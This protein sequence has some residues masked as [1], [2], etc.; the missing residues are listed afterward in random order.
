MYC[1][2]F[3]PSL[4]TTELILPPLF[5]ITTLIFSFSIEYSLVFKSA[6]SAK[7]PYLLPFS[8]L[9]NCGFSNV[10]ISVS[11]IKFSVFISSLFC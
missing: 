8:S 7:T 1:F 3:G 11:V 2:L 9:V 6:D 5:E 10:T 4:I